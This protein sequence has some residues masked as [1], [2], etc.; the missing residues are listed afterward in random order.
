MPAPSAR[1]RDAIDHRDKEGADAL[2]RDQVDQN[3]HERR[4]AKNPCQHV[5]SHFDLACSLI[6]TARCPVVAA[7]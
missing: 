1:R 7:R 3:E 5:F 4:D 6:T 2:V